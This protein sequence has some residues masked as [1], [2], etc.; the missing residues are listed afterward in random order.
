MRIRAGSSQAAAGFALQCIS[1]AGRQMNF[2]CA[3][4][5][6]Q[7]S[8]ILQIAVEVATRGDRNAY[9]IVPKS[10]CDSAMNCSP[11]S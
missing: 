8:K 9:G 2:I 3:P 4:R 1:T 5:R 11:I 10:C 7:L 6:D